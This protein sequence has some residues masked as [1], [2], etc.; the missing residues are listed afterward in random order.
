MRFALLG[1]KSCRTYTG[2]MRRQMTA[3]VDRHCYDLLHSAQAN[4]LLVLRC[5]RRRI[6]H[7]HSRSARHRSDYA[8]MRCVLNASSKAGKV[9]LC[10]QSIILRQRSASW[11][12]RI[13]GIYPVLRR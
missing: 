13:P 4:L 6:Q 3:V 9:R 1:V 10:C 11:V 8:R 7:E 12:R 5:G 2:A